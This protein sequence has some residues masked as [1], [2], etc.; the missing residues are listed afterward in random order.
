M[1]LITFADIA[2]KYLNEVG[3]TAHLFGSKNEARLLMDTLP[4][5]GFWPCLFSVSDTTGE[6]D[7][8]GFFTASE[9]MDMESFENLGVIK[10]DSRENNESLGMFLAEISRL[11]LSRSWAKTQLVDLFHKMIPAFSHKETGKYLDDKM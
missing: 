2:I 3:F 10:D 4:E 11:K 9:I 1:H 6:K 7:F 8:E 5:R